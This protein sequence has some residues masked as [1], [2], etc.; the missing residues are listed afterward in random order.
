MTNLENL[1]QMRC[2]RD[3]EAPAGASPVT[4]RRHAALQRRSR[5]PLRCPSDVNAPGAAGATPRYQE[6]GEPV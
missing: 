6:I 1:I 5:R 4:L 2:W 3:V